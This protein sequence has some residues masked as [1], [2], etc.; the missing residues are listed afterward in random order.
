[1]IAA[2]LEPRERRIRA[3]A[4]RIARA[5]RETPEMRAR[6]T[7]SQ[8]AAKKALPLQ[9]RLEMAAGGGEIAGVESVLDEFDRMNADEDPLALRYALQVFL[10]HSSAA[11][12][13]GLGVP[14]LSERS[15]WL[16]VPSR[17]G[18]TEDR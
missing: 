2:Q 18:K 3:L 8:Y 12:A 15:P 4:S 11:Q 13:L 1:M 9:R 7:F 5:L 17:A 16:T 6:S 10:T 14:S